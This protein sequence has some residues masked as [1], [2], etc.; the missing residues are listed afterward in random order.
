MFTS[1][2][3]AVT[4]VRWIQ[5]LTE[6]LSAVFYVDKISLGT[7]S[8]EGLNDFSVSCSNLFFGSWYFVSQ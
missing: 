2:G 6:F 1:P 4:S 5:A 8:Q 3:V 7:P